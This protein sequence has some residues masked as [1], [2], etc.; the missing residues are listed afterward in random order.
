MSP[1][2]VGLL[3]VSE[4]VGVGLVG[5]VAIRLLRRYP[6]GVSVIAVVVTTVCMVNASTVTVLLATGSTQLSASMQLVLTS[7]AGV[8]ALAIG[9]VLG[10]A[11]LTGGTRLADATRE[12]G[13]RQRFRLAAEPPTAELAELARELANTSEQLSESRRREHAAETSRRHLVGWISH[14]LRSPLTRLR[15]TAESI[16]DGMVTDL[17]DHCRRIRQDADRLTGM[18]DD[19]F[20]LSRI[21]AG[22]LRLRQHQLSIDDLVSD[23]VAGVAEQ[24]ARRNVRL[25]PGRIEPATVSI[26]EEAMARVFTNLLTNAI[27]YSPPGTTVS[28]DVHAANG[29]V[30]VSVADQCG[31]I[32]EAHLDSVFEMGWRGSAARTGTAGNTSGGGFG[33]AIVR[34]MVQAHRGTVTAS[35]VE[36]G[37]C[38]SVRLPTV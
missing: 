29:G 3:A 6:I 30:T 7:V 5:V 32:P 8:V 9:I 11:V 21:Q 12:F 23:V 31:G 27:Q 15:A 16:E 19:L 25:R 2:L 37:C 38:F 26:D 14:D 33:L 1:L 24:A 28:V 36:G 34:G 4:S 10:R 22:S 35:N 18:V 20:E 13:Q 17:V